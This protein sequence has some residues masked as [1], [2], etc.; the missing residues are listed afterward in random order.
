MELCIFV[1]LQY[2]M[3]RQKFLSFHSS[4]CEPIISLWKWTRFILNVD[5]LRGVTI[6]PKKQQW[7]L[8]SLFLAH[9]PWC[10]AAKWLLVC[11]ENDDVSRSRLFIILIL[12]FVT[13]ERPWGTSCFAA[14]PID[15]MPTSNTR[16]KETNKSL[17]TFLSFGSNSFGQ[18]TSVAV[19]SLTHVCVML[20]LKFMR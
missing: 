4:E 3:K 19:I 14:M 16:V 17:M 12:S 11:K 2:Y 7:R 5:R 6:C 9:I 15:L 20:K 13:S 18:R 10:D 1:K 8:K